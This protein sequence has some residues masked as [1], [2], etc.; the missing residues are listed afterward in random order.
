M[1]A[2]YQNRYSPSPYVSYGAPVYYGG[3]AP[4]QAPGAGL[5]I[6][7]LLSTLTGLMAA[8]QQL[9]GGWQGFVSQ[10]FAIGFPP[11]APAPGYG[12]GPVVPNRNPY[13][14][15]PAGHGSAG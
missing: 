3:G 4:T 6:Q 12:S 10:P 9:Y 15:L 14:L 8:T 5:S 13:S 11:F 1:D 7:S 2:L